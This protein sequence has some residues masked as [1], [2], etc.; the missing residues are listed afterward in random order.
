VVVVVSIASL[1]G[2]TT[3]PNDVGWEAERTSR[4]LSKARCIWNGAACC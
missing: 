4:R 2:R 1:F 3:S